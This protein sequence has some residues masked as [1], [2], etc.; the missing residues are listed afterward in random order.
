MANDL[1]KEEA[2]KLGGQNLVEKLTD[3]ADSIHALAALPDAYE[4]RFEDLEAMTAKIING[5][6][7]GDTEGHRR[8]HDAVIQKMDADRR[9]K[10]AVTEKI[11][12]GG[13]WAA[14]VGVAVLLYAGFLHFIGVN[15]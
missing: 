6:P 9:L 15:K 13:I 2:A 12:S 5:F 8:F 3:M 4:Q 11:I 14:I 1:W 10:M 7:G